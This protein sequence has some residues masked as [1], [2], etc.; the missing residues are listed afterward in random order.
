MRPL[1]NNLVEAYSPLFF[2]AS[3]GSGGIA[4][5]FFMYLMFMLDHEGRPIPVFADVAAALSSGGLV[6]GGLVVLSLAGIVYYSYQHYRLL[7]WNVREYLIFKKTGAFQELK[8][9]DAE[10]QLM[11]APLTYA[12]GINVMFVLG[13]VFVPGLWNFV[14]YL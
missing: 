4:V 11:A 8:S 3:L 14:E 1:R 12:M 9:S 2:L 10:V 6:L 7:A 5:S 13:A